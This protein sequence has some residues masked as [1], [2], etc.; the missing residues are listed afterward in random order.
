[1]TDVIVGVVYATLAYVAVQ[2]VVARRARAS[3]ER[4]QDQ[5]P[6]EEAGDAASEGVPA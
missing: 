1:V 5:L 6:Y 4:E 3:R 2:V